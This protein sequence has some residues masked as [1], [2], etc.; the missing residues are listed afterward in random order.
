MI[1]ISH[2][3]LLFT[4]G[5]GQ[6][7]IYISYQSY[8]RNKSAHLFSYLLVLIGFNAITLAH[9]IETFLK[10]TAPD[11]YQADSDLTYILLAVIRILI[12]YHMARFLAG[13]FQKVWNRKAITGV[14]LII[15]GFLALQ[16]VSL[17][18][19]NRSIRIPQYSA[20]VVHFV[21]F[22]VLSLLLIQGL[23]FARDLRNLSRKRALTLFMG[24]LLLFNC[25]LFMN[26]IGGYI[27][28][29]SLNTQMLIISILMLC[30][31]FFHVFFFNRFLR[32]YLI[33]Y[34]K[35]EMN[36]FDFLVQKFQI[37]KREKDIILLICEGKTNKDIAA[38]LFLSP[39]TVRDHL[40]RIYEKTNSKS[41]LQL[42]NLFHGNSE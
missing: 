42:A 10:A 34:P 11:T 2:F 36:H 7:A 23:R 5:V 14:I 40:S 31:N 41:R 24:F 13:L 1:S 33:E 28:W 12:L 9:T 38:D 4:L 25:L 35:P 15:A 27:S 8:K 16:T 37:S 30:Y 19:F 3:L 29:I 21:F 39:V 20:M 32:E 22:A 26:R 6:V 18:G 17:V